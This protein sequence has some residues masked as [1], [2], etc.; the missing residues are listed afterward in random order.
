MGD[1]TDLKSFH[2]KREEYVFEC[3]CGG[4][5]FYLNVDGSVECRSCDRI[6][7]KIE[8]NYRK[9]SA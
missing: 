6:I 8:W 5:H 4:Q 3:A 2:K 7:Q 1:V 9:E